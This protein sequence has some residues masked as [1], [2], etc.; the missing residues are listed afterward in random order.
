[1]L[2]DREVDVW[3]SAQAGADAHLVKPL[4]SMNLRRAVLGLL[5]AEPV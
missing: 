3:L 2:L 4:D 1:M 5:A